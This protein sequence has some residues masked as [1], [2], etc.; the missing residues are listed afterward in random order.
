MSDIPQG[1]QLTPF[2]PEFERDPYSV[3]ARLREA[4]PV[5]Y[6]GISYTVSGYDEV[7]SLLRDRRLSVD[8][9]KVGQARDPRANNS[10]T[11]RAPDMMNLDNPDHA[12][13]R[14]LVNRAFTPSSVA[15]FRPR[16]EAMADA[17][18]TEL[19]REF[20]AIA[21]YASPLSTRVIA[22]YMGM[23]PGLHADFRGW[24]D[25]LLMQGYPMPTGEQW[26]K[27]VDADEA[28]RNCSP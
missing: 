8:A 5:H 26:Q 17:L 3:Y 2:D 21:C 24:T 27:I 14:G 20:D 15:S 7:A 1:I 22:E 18:V 12:R 11:R 28:M 13:L 6:D 23:E 19:P 25:T 9:R 4:E 10:V 16:I